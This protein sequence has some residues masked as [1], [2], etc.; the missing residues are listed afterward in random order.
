[1]DK[2][3]ARVWRNAKQLLK[4]F[5]GGHIEFSGAPCIVQCWAEQSDA[6]RDVAAESFMYIQ[7]RLIATQSAAA[8]A[9]QHSCVMLIDRKLKH[10]T[11]IVAHY[12]T[13]D[14][15]AVA[16]DSVWSINNSE[17]GAPAVCEFALL[18]GNLLRSL[19]YDRLVPCRGEDWWS[20]IELARVK[21]H[22]CLTALA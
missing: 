7:P 16:C 1:M 5:S 19:I 20:E 3:C 8:P 2:K 13:T 21:G 11:R 12:T 18:G 6:F 4:S 10:N 15:G 22:I 14:K 9:A 17:L